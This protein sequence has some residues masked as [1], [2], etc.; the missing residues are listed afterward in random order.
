MGRCVYRVSSAAA[1]LLTVLIAAVTVAATTARAYDHAGV[2]VAG[3]LLVGQNEEGKLGTNRILNPFA[4]CANFDTTDVTDTAL[5]IGGASYFFTFDRH[6][7]YLSF[8][9]GQ[10]S[11]NLNSGP[12]D[13][14]RLTG[15]FGCTTVRTT[16]SSG[17][18]ISTVYYVQNDGFLYW[19][20]NSVVYVTLVKNGISLFDVT[21]YKGNLYLLSAQ[22][23]I[24]KCLIG[25]GG[26][27][28]G[29]ACTQVMLAGS[30]AYAN[31]SETSTSEFKGFAVS[32]AGIFIA[33][34]SSLYW[35]NL[36]GGY[37]ASTT[38]A[39]VFVDV[40]LTSNRDTANP[41]IPTLMA[42]STSAVYRVST[43]G[44][45][46]TYTLIAGKETATCNLALDNVDSLTDPSFCGIARIYPLSLDVVYMTTAG[47]SVVRAIV[48][49]N[50]TIRDT[51]TR[52]P[53]PLYFLDRAST[54]PV[55]LDGMNY[56]IVGHS[57]V[58]FPYVAID[59]STPEVNDT[60]W[61]TSF[62]VDISNRFFSMASSAAVT[63][64]PFMGSLHGLET[65]YNRTN[66]IIFGDPNVLPMCN[67]TKMLMIERAV[68]TAARAALKYPYIY[69][70]NAQN[71]TVNAQPNLTLVK[72]LMP[73]AFGEILNELG[74]FENTTT[75]A[76]LAAVQFNTTMLAA[77]RSAYMMDRVYDCIFSGNAYPFHVLTAAQQQEVRWIIYSA[78][79]N[80]LAR[81]NQSIPYLGPDSNSSNSYNN[82]APGC[83]P[84]IGINNLTEML[85]PGLPYSNFNITVFIPESLY[86]NFGISRCLDGTDWTDVMGY[87]INATT[88]NNR[89]C[90]TGCIVGIAVASALVASF[91]VVAIVIMTSKRRR[92][93]TV[94]AP[95]ATSEPKFI[96]TL[97]MTSEEGS[98]NPL[99]R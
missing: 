72:L 90:N 61:D 77:V 29:S 53:F 71:F 87:L 59:Q 52:T 31:L 94:V 95:A 54:I 75:A 11:M 39:V 99:T 46:I 9:Y 18:P 57:N 85:L 50:T 40:K 7:T 63:S 32:S 28:T 33:P 82:M 89:K 78:I 20:M 73:Y 27:V 41:G 45:S 48:V 3:A 15:V 8:W 24:Y 58:P 21:V 84:R 43:A 49:S 12:I 38:T 26:A 16:S 34:S 66:Q 51:I 74:F 22:N 69:T 97:D 96:S 30:T 81:C 2:T 67:L 88:R 76:A 65:Y 92:L 47:A 68:A 79:Q 37:I 42:A 55:L 98:R 13:Q 70:S 62:G 17:S 86:Y 64:T 4:L 35:F 93:A 23:S 19:V 5:L 14:V 80:Q 91:L 44:T 6:S 60:T 56:E 10:G 36:A 25:P 83:V 1:T